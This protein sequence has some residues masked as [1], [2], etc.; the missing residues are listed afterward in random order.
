MLQV[1]QGFHEGYKVLSDA[2][3]AAVVAIVDPAG[4]LCGAACQRVLC[5]G[6]SL[7]AA[8][9]GICAVDMATAVDA[10]WLP[11]SSGNLRVKMSNFGMPRVGNAPFAAYFAEHVGVELEQATR[12]VHRHDI[13]PHLP[14]QEMPEGMRFHHVAREVWDVHETAVGYKVCDSNGE[15]PTCSDSVDPLLWSPADH[16]LYLDV[17][18]NN[19]H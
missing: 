18:Q 6:H 9:S 11:R 7:G 1:H 8:L 17:P 16:M 12:V 14:L 19:C 15:D 13:V 5:T 2:I 10:G 4:T 3:H